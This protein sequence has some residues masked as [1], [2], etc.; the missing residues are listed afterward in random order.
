M[1]P[2]QVRGKNIFTIKKEQRMFE[3]KIYYH[4]DCF[5]EFRLEVEADFESRE[6]A[7]AWIEG[8][9]SIACK[10]EDPENPISDLY[11]TSIK[12]VK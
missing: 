7:A 11:D 2:L 5:S 6:E 8:Y 9:L 12:E 3:A 4:S 10:G 1:P